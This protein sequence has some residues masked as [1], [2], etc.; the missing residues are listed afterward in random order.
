M[1]FYY[2]PYLIG[3]VSVL[4]TDINGE[5]KFKSIRFHFLYIVATKYYLDEAKE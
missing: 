5:S 3:A 4:K 2:P 1:F